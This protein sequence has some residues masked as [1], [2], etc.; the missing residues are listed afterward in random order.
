MTKRPARGISASWTP[1]LASLGRYESEVALDV[2]EAG[3]A[4]R[5]LLCGEQGRQAAHRVPDQMEPPRAEEQLRGPARAV[6]TRNGTE[7]LERSRQV[8]LPLPGVSYARNGRPSNS[9]CM[10]MSR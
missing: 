2:D 7:S 4:P 6:A 3:D 9:F 8:E 5:D 10:Q 1:A